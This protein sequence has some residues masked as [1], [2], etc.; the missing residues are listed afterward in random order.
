MQS[1][2]PLRRHE[3]LQSVKELLLGLMRTPG[4]QDFKKDEVR[5]TGRP[6]LE[7]MRACNLRVPKSHVRVCKSS[8]QGC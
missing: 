2:I 4:L 5:G 6:F 3:G 8:F 1:K 7:P